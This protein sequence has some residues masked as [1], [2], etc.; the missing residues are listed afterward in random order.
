MKHVKEAGGRVFTC[1]WGCGTSDH[2]RDNLG[3]HEVKCRRGRRARGSNPSS[4]EEAEV[5]GD[6]E[7][8]IERGGEDVAIVLPR[9]V[10][11]ELL[12]GISIASPRSSVNSATFESLLSTPELQSSTLGSSPL[13]SHDLKTPESTYVTLA[14]GWDSPPENPKMLDPM[15]VGMGMNAGVGMKGELGVGTGVVD[16]AEMEALGQAGWTGWDVWEQ[17]M[18]LGKEAK[19]LAWVEEWVQGGRAVQ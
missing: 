3:K 5:E 16:M 9:T 8:E 19:D 2:R 6:G 10:E 17:Q 1:R 15:G 12:P 14:A 13:S 11:E 18:G 4:D 7:V